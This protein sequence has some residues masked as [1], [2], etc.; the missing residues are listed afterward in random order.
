MRNN[1][2]ND[3]LAS[4]LIISGLFL[5]LL[6]RLVPDE[7]IYKVPFVDIAFP[8]MDMMTLFTEG[9]TGVYLLP[10]AL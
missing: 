9:F 6:W 2:N 10:A 1:L 5:C 4:V 7:S 8:T 3:L